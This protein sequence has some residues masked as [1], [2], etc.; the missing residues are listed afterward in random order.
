[1]WHLPRKIFDIDTRSF[2]KAF[3]KDWK[4]RGVIAEKKAFNEK[5]TSK[6]EINVKDIFKTAHIWKNVDF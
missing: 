1:M 5:L 6:W 3:E 4:N 2:N